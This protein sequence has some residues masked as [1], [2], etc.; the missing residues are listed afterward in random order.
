MSELDKYWVIEASSTLAANEKI[1]KFEKQGYKLLDVKPYQGVG[2]SCFIITMYLPSTP[3][4]GNYIGYE[5]ADIGSSRQ[6]ELERL[7]YKAMA[8]YSKHITWAKPNEEN[9]DALDKEI[10][11]LAKF[12]E[13]IEDEPIRLMVDGLIG[14]YYHAKTTT[15]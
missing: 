10:D 3:D 9:I 13:W 12:M 2:G 11:I 15:S 8:N 7:G 14:D 4:L 5:N 1:A 6:I